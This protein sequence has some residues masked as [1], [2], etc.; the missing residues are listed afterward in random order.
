[1]LQTNNNTEIK[2]PI[3]FVAQ[4]PEECVKLAKIEQVCKTPNEKVRLA[5]AKRN[6]ENTKPIRRLNSFAQLAYA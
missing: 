3:P 6:V 1:M 2:N 5:Y 4:M